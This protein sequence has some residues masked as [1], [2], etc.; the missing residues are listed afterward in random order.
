MKEEQV[1][2]ARSGQEVAV[3]GNGNGNGRS[4]V[5]EIKA[6]GNWQEACRRSVNAANNYTGQDGLILRV[7][8]Q[9]F[10]MEFP[11]QNTHFCTEL[12]ESIERLPGIFRVYET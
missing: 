12:I 10:S 8:G 5:V 3:P 9:S 1:Y 11:N 6:T 4:V 7:T 2:T